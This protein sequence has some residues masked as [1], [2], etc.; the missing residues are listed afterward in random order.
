MIVDVG[1]AA[2]GAAITLLYDAVKEM[3][4]KNIM[5]KP[6]L[7]SLMATLEILKPLMKEVKQLN[8]LLTQR[9]QESAYYESQIKEGEKHIR[10]CSRV[11]R[12]NILNKSYYTNKLLELDQNLKSLII[13]LS[14]ARDCKETLIGVNKILELLPASGLSA[15]DSNEMLDLLRK[16]FDMIQRSQGINI[17]ESHRVTSMLSSNTSTPPLPP[18][19]PKEPLPPP[20][21][22]PP[23]TPPNVKAPPPPS[24]PPPF[25][26][27]NSNVSN[28]IDNYGSAP[29]KSQSQ[30]INE[31][32]DNV[33][34]ELHGG[35]RLAHP[36]RTL[37]DVVREVKD[38]A[39]MFK[40]ILNKLEAR[41]RV[42]APLLMEIQRVDRELDLP[43]SEAADIMLEM[44]KG[45]ALVRKCSKIHWFKLCIKPYYTGMLLELDDTL[46]RL[47][48]I[49]QV[50]AARDMKKNLVL[51]RE[52][53]AKITGVGS[54]TI[55][56]R[57]QILSR[58]S[59]I[60]S[61]SPTALRG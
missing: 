34:V 5:F 43:E 40:P 4:K 37:F 10:K 22:P 48:Q 32:Q 16:I 56:G 33:A 17:A 52:M 50:Q 23:L 26:D 38:K 29:G 21:P 42:M 18:P 8:E 45:T 20:P 58:A 1:G 19:K 53:Q 44:E 46:C 14:S 3:T 24:P 31:G 54:N 51:V 12:Y 28:N 25:S 35:I 9:I 59:S 15:V 13:S 11:G 7:R 27:N 49:L 60:V 57:N 55:A 41:L 47:L 36:F 2:L 39:L 6:S 30:N 61:L